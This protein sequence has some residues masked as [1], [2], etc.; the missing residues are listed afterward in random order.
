ML[1]IG[2]P[3]VF[4]H[5]DS[6]IGMGRWSSRLATFSPFNACRIGHG[7]VV[8]KSYF[9]GSRAS[10][11]PAKRNALTLAGYIAEDATWAEFETGWEKILHS[12]N[13]SCNYMHM[14]EAMSLRKEFA[15]EKGWTREK[16]RDLLTRLIN[17]LRASRWNDRMYAV[18][19]TVILDD[20]AKAIRE[21][22]QLSPPHR[23]CAHVCAGRAFNWQAQKLAT[24]PEGKIAVVQS[25]DFFFDQNEPFLHHFNSEWTR[26]RRAKHRA[27]WWDLVNTVAPADMR[28]LPPLQLAD[29]LAWAQSRSM[30][31]GDQE[32]LCQGIIQSADM[33]EFVLDYDK[34]V[35]PRRLI[36][37]V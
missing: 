11:P 31:T 20:H 15:K 3:L 19:C 23:I 27:L 16:V 22:F 1:A 4:E 7:F 33:S 35:N 12:F 9:D 25:A 18:S 6:R 24:T 32:V 21:G 34:L 2:E 28:K 26:N 36:E 14:K 29:M 13:P 8:L 5:C 17:F 10:K 30:A 37:S